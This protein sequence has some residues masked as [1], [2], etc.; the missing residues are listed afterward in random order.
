[1]PSKFRRVRTFPDTTSSSRWKTR[2]TTKRET[3]ISKAYRTNSISRP[4]GVPRF[5]LA[6]TLIAVRTTAATKAPTNRLRHVRNDGRIS[7]SCG[8]TTR[9]DPRRERRGDLPRPPPWRGGGHAQILRHGPG[10]ALGP[11]E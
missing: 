7:R 8:F 9:W 3:T 10:Y 1:R 4:T 2:S 11:H 6:A 5:Q